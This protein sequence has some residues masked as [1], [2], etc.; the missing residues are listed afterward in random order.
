METGERPMSDR[1]RQKL[2]ARRLREQ[3]KREA[4]MAEQQQSTNL[5][6]RQKRKQKQRAREAAA[7][8]D[9]ATASGTAPQRHAQ[10]ANGERKQH[11]KSQRQRQQKQ[12]K[13]REQQQKLQTHRV[14]SADASA[15]DKPHSAPSVSNESN[16]SASTN[17]VSL[18]VPTSA[19]GTFSS[20]VGSI[21]RPAGLSTLVSLAPAST[22][23]GPAAARTVSSC[24]ALTRFSHKQQL[25]LNQ[26]GVPSSRSFLVAPLSSAIGSSSCPTHL[27]PHLPQLETLASA[28]QS[29][30]FA[31]SFAEIVQSSSAEPHSRVRS[32]LTPAPLSSTAAAAAT[33]IASPPIPRLSP[34]SHP[35]RFMFDSVAQPLQQ[36]RQMPRSSSMIS[37]AGGFAQYPM[38]VCPRLPLPATASRPWQQIASAHA[39]RA[40]LRLPFS[41]QRP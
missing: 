39:P 32:R 4:R 17:S 1:E 18:S 8:A 21:R 38:Q 41:T 20:R 23:S 22:S 19:D 3:R 31:R 30:A 14:D 2:F 34:P 13:W 26:F 5:S 35:P 24:V 27:S 12:N 9:S 37:P 36:Q 15:V 10:G 28:P 16:T 40:L 25:Q 7:G 29:N 11:S 33:P 6:R